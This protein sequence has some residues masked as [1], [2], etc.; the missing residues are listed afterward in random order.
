MISLPELTPAS[1]FA[2]IPRHRYMV[3]SEVLTVCVYIA[4]M[5]VLKSDFG[6]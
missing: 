5:A 3:Y 2:I 4:S 6:E 1:P